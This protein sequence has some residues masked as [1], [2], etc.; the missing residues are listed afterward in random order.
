MTLYWRRI[1]T[2]P[3]RLATHLK[4]ELLGWTAPG[5]ICVPQ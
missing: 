5:G 3:R 2:P 1:G 4:R